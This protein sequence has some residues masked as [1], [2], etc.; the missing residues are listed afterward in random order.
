MARK[1]KYSCLVTK[2]QNVNVFTFAMK[3]K[4]VVFI[5][6]VAARGVDDEEGAVQRLLVTRRVNAIRDFVRRGN[7]FFNTFILNWTQKSDIPVVDRGA[8]EITL[9]LMA[10]S[11]QVIDGQH[12]LAGLERAMDDDPA[13]GEREILVSL[14]VNLT[15]KE[16]AQIFL[17]I[18]TEQKPVPKSLIYDLFGEADS[19]PNHLINR[20]NDIAV[21]L[22]ENEGS[23]YYSLIK[24][25]GMSKG[26]GAIDLSTVVSS[27]KPHLSQ[28]GAFA[29]YNL[30]S[31]QYQKTTILNFFSAVKFFYDNQGLWENKAK[32]P[33]LRAAGFT[34]AIDF[35]VESVLSKC[36][37]TKNF[38]VERIKEFIRLDKTG[39]LL[40]EDIRQLDGKTARRTIKEHLEAHIRDQTPGQDE[41]E[42]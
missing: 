2:F 22:N 32:N 8:K 26:V 34:G 12:R 27:L 3:V 36:A 37:E 15:T 11:A 5:H 28:G 4:D 6:Y 18:N 16:A 42:F 24:F 33:F 19:D 38:S 41:Y 21:E 39:V 35:L 13:I 20:A 31:L 23:P 29:K 14:T 10:R 25:P 7:G 40:M 1:K 30:S 17:N 9:P